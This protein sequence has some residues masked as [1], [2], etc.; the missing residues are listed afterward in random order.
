MEQH[1]LLL[2]SELFTKCQLSD[3]NLNYQMK[4]IEESEGFIEHK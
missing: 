1:A 2:A 3:P 4:L